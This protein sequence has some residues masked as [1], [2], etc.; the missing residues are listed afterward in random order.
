VI[1]QEVAHAFGSIGNP[2]GWSELEQKF[3]ALVQPTLD[4]KAKE[5]LEV[6][7]DFQNVGSMDRM[8]ELT[9]HLPNSRAQ[10]NP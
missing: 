7:R 4:E 8:F 2:L 10:A 3:M 5:L 1:T 9:T 6:L